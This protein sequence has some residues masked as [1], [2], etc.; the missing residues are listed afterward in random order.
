MPEI[1]C[2]VIGSLVFGF[3]RLFSTNVPGRFVQ[4]FIRGKL[5]NSDDSGLRGAGQTHRR[6]LG[7]S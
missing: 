4:L 6:E 3:S 7:G 1:L 5:G 2:G